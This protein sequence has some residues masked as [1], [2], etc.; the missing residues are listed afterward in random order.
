MKQIVVQAGASRIPPDVE[1]LLKRYI[2]D[3]VDATRNKILRVASSIPKDFKTI[4]KPIYRGTG[5]R[6][7]SIDKLLTRGGV[8]KDHTL[9]SWSYN[10]KEALNFA[11]M[12]TE[13]GRPGVLLVRRTSEN[14]VINFA[15]NLSRFGASLADTVDLYDQ[16]EVLIAVSNADYKPTD[17]AAVCVNKVN[18]GWLVKTLGW[19]MK[20]KFGWRSKV[21]IVNP[22]TR[23]TILEYA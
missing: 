18:F 17:V 10:A 7:V 22:G 15:D 5:L 3:G 23:P 14:V 9:T 1:R 13:I 21:V 20:A 19:K 6:G 8:V 12:N 16:E 2:E 11:I 4:H